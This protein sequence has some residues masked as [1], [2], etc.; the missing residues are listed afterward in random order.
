M[1]DLLGHMNIGDEEVL[2][3]VRL[4]VIVLHDITDPELI[5]DADSEKDSDFVVAIEQL[6]PVLLTLIGQGSNYHEGFW[7][8]IPLAKTSYVTFLFSAN[9]NK[10]E[11]FTY[12]V[13]ERRPL[14]NYV[15][16]VFAI[17][18]SLVPPVVPLH[19]IENTIHW[20]V[21]FHRPIHEW[22]Q[23]TF[24]FLKKVFIL[25]IGGTNV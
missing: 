11:G 9:F 24:D 6:W 21:D 16:F 7:G 8:P 25:A 18:K 10:T 2:D 14:S 3:K 15:L 12:D 17:D 5:F 1:Q 23:K 20:Y 13:R 4:C 19:E 22:S